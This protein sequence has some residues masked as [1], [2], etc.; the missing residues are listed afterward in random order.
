M[1][2]ESDNRMENMMLDVNRALLH[3]YG[4]NIVLNKLKEKFLNEYDIELDYNKIFHIKDERTNT[5]FVR[6]IK[7]N[8]IFEGKLKFN[9]KL[10]LPLDEINSA[11]FSE[12]DLI[13]NNIIHKVLS[14]KELVLSLIKNTHIFSAF[15]NKFYTI[16]NQLVINEVFSRDMID[17][18][19]S[20]NKNFKKYIS[21]VVDEGF[22]EIDSKKNLKAS[23]K[24]KVLFK[25]KKDVK[26]TVDEALFL[27]I[28]NHYDYIIYELNIHTLKTYIN[29]VSCLIYLIDYMELK[30]IK[31]KLGDLYRVYLTFYQKVNFDKFLE[32]INNLVYSN[33]ITSDNGVVSL[34]G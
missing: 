34:T 15:L 21:L 31:M 28:K 19:T 5:L 33:V 20:K 26:E 3:N 4:N 7:F 10:E 13:K 1:T 16:L 29:I 24:L 32:R 14:R 9:E 8:T 30:N 25:N 22:G 27:L 6:N 18:L 17:E 23:N 12:Y 11:I 2:L